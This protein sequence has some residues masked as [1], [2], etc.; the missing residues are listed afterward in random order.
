MTLVVLSI[1]LVNV[2]VEYAW[3]LGMTLA[4]VEKAFEGLWWIMLIATIERV[5]LEMLKDL[6]TFLVSIFF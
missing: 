6:R 1:V 5:I 3:S 4:P 2:P